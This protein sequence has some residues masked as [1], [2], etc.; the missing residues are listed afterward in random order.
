MR[1]RSIKPEFW[2]SDDIT[3]LSIS[4]RLTFIGLWSYV[5]DNGVGADKLA[6]IT[7]DL[8]A[9]D[10]ERDPPETFQRVSGDLQEIHQKGLITRYKVGG[11]PYLYVNT[12]SKHQV[13]N[14]PSIGHKYPLPTSEN[15]DPPE[16]L[17]TPSGDTPET[18]G[19][20]AGEQGNRGTGEQGR[21]TAVA[22]ATAPT[23]KRGSRLPDDWMPRE[24]IVQ[25]M[26]A[27]C[28]GVNLEAEHRKFVDHWQA[29]SGAKGTKLDWN[30]TWCNWIRRAGEWSTVKPAPAARM[31]DV[32]AIGDRL[33]SMYDQKELL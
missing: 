7:A 26:Q 2:R 21:G 24:D 30:K 32:A 25:K 12:W 4:A 16:S 8:F 5:D 13:I 33:Q 19:Y 29:V 11:K 31:N 28:P 27:E 18:L 17:H 14:K 23:P 1:I 20:G 6:S 15:S 10:L 22:V 3:A 9:P